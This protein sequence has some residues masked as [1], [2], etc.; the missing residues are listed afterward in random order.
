MEKRV[1]QYHYSRKKGIASYSSI[2]KATT[3]LYLCCS[4]SSFAQEDEKKDS[5]P[6]IWKTNTKV[7]F[8]LNQSTF[9]NWIAGGSNSVA[10]NLNLNYEFNYN[11]DNWNWDNKVTS[12]FGLS[13]V[14]E[15]G[16]RKTDDRFEYNSIL[17]YKSKNNWFFS[18]YD[19]L[20]TQYTKGYDYSKTPKEEVSNFFSPA[21]LSFGPGFLWK[22]SKTKYVNIAPSSSRFTFVSDTFS[23]KYGVDE[24]RNSSF[25]LGF[26]LSSYYKFTL[27]KD[28][29]MEN[30]LALYSDYL[31]KPQNVD[32]DYQLNFLLKINKHLS[33]NLG[34]H[35]IVDDNASSKIQ[36]R[37]L[38]GLGVNY[39]I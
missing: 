37:Q 12:G 27:A 11:K 1:L 23:G 25:S 4:F 39:I 26:N 21:Y 17:S 15:Q 28:V 8:L 29:E 16:T 36:F 34:F 31:D 32:V 13:Y 30:T 3:L 6:K 18:F 10:G 24:G 14:D 35:T 33:T 7:T 9:S 19:N 2:I 38:F 5:I 20:K 22:K